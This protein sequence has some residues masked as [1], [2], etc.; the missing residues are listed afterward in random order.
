MGAD[1]IEDKESVHSNELDNAE[2]YATEKVTKEEILVVIDSKVEQLTQDLER[3]LTPEEMESISQLLSADP[4]SK[5]RQSLDR[6][7]QGMRE[8]AELKISELEEETESEAGKT[9]L[10][11]T[12]PSINIEKA[13]NDVAKI[14]QEMESK[15]TDEA[16]KNSSF[17]KESE[18]NAFTTFDH[19]ERSLPN[20]YVEQEQDNVSDADPVDPVVARLKKRIESMVDKIEVQLSDVQVKIGDKLHYLDK[21]M[22]GILSRKEMASVLSQVLKNISFGDA[23]TIAD[24]MDEN[25]D[26]VFTVQ[27]LISWIE[28]NKL[29]KFESEGRDAEM[30]KIMEIHTNEEE[31]TPT[32]SPKTKGDK[33]V[34]KKE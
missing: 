2:N 14:I 23:L 17:T 9:T 27:E 32:I 15:A 22:D 3:E 18:I 6:I 5:E 28:T 7:K 13:D 11:T 26:G 1:E 34:D 21:D 4:V 30:D 25:K 12:E 31:S 8:K 29:V 16:E 10:V 19:T 24:E 20:D 33:A